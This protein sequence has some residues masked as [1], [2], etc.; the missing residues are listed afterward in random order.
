MVQDA[1]GELAD[2]LGGHAQH[3]GAGTGRVRQRAEHVEDG[4]DP[5]FLADGTEVTHGRMEDG[6]EA[7]RDAQLSAGLG[8]S[9]SGKGSDAR[10]SAVSSPST[11]IAESAA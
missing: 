9:R 6:C 7:E 2:A 11:A 1:G 10:A 5:Q 8:G 3:L 4:A